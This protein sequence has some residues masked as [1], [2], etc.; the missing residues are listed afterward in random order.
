MLKRFIVIAAL[1]GFTAIVAST[2]A[3]ASTYTRCDDRGCYRVH[4]E[5][6]RCARINI[7]GYYRNRYYVPSGYYYDAPPYP[8]YGR[9]YRVC[10][11]WGCH[12]LREPRAHVTV[13]V[14][15]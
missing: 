15:F 3:A 8:Y 11:R 7:D 2:S 9:P 4:C 14:R 13:G 5:W 1:A 10:D 6:G 12:Y